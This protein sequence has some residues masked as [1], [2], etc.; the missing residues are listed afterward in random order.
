MVA[1]KGPVIIYGGGRHRK[2]FA[3]STIKK[4]KTFLPTSNIN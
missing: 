2:D 1:A 3:D 4:S